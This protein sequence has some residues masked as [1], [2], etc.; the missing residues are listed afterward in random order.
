MHT[1]MCYIDNKKQ[2]FKHNDLMK[3]QSWK[4]II[5]Y[6]FV[7]AHVSLHYTYIV[8]K[9]REFFFKKL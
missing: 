2:H 9:E 4:K 5:I 1:Y 7:K 8:V 3:V 6:K